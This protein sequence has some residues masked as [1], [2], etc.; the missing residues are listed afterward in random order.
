VDCLTLE[1]G[2]IVCPE[3]SVTDYKPTLLHI[4]QERRSYRNTALSCDT[5]LFVQKAEEDIRGKYD[6][7]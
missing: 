5:D 2:K 6:L 1:E 4:P 7:E 3:T